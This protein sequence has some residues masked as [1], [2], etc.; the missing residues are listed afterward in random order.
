MDRSKAIKGEGVRVLGNKRQMGGFSVFAH[1]IFFEDI[2]N[3]P[4]IVFF[5]DIPVVPEE[6]NSE[7]VKTRG[8]VWLHTEHYHLYFLLQNILIQLIVLMRVDFA[9]DWL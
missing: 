2:F 4:Y 3:H 8:L 9:L 5:N 6:G 1:L 7:V